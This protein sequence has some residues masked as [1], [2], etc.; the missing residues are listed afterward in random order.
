[1]GIHDELTVKVAGVA[2]LDEAIAHLPGDGIIF[3]SQAEVQ[4]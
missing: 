1:L 2:R 3:I 4:C